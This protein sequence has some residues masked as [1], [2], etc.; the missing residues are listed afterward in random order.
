MI[1]SPP[2]AQ[3]LLEVVVTTCCGHDIG[4]A[5]ALFSQAG[6]PG[7]SSKQALS[8]S[9]LLGAGARLRVYE[10]GGDQSSTARLRQQLHSLMSYPDALRVVALVNANGREAHTIAHHIAERHDRLARITTFVQADAAHKGGDHMQALL[11]LHSAL[12]HSGAATTGLDPTAAVDRVVASMNTANA[13]T[14]EACLCPLSAP[15]TPVLLCETSG[16]NHPIWPCPPAAALADGSSHDRYHAGGS[17]RPSLSM[18]GYTGLASFVMRSFLREPTWAGMPVPWC[19]AATLSVTA[20]QA[21]V[22]KPRVW[23]EAMRNLLERDGR[24]KWVSALRMA[25]TLERLWL[26]IFSQPVMPPPDTASSL[27]SSPESGPSAELPRCLTD[28]NTTCCVKHND[29]CCPTLLSPPTAG[30]RPRRPSD[31]LFKMRSL[32]P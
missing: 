32:P 11:L 2:R 12:L 27:S 6:L 18:G 22:G 13:S 31:A 10:K 5:G 4:W 1:A 28:R 26:R 25:H 14:A 16:G 7:P 19:P 20:E 3:P 29:C 17:F 24:V 8:L 21:T 23:W 30:L 9:K 15:K